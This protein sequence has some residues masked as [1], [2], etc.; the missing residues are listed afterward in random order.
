[1]PSLTLSPILLAS[2]AL[3]ALPVLAVTVHPRG[4]SVDGT[5]EAQSAVDRCPSG[6]S[7]IFA[8]GTYAVSGLHLKGGCTYRGEKGK[9]ILKLTAKDRF[10]FDFSE[11]SDIRIE[12]LVFDGNGLGGGLQA[13]LNGP[14]RNIHV[15]DCA[16]RNVSNKATYPANLAIYSSWAFLDSEIANNTFENIAGG[17]MLT[18]VQHV[19]ISGNTFRDVTLSDAIFIAP[20]PVPFPSGERIVIANNTG[21]GIAKMG[22]EIFRPDPPNG[23]NM[24]EPLIENNSFSRFTAANHE[25]MGLSIT[26]GDGA[27]VRDNR[28]DNTGGVRQDNG[29]GIEVI[30]RNARVTGNSIA[31]GMGFGI[32][33]QGTPGATL[34]SNHISGMWKDGILFACDNGRNRCDSSGSRVEGNT[35]ENARLNGIRLDN[36]WSNSTILSNTI[37]RQAGYWPDDG[38]IAFT[39]IRTCPARQAVT[40][41]GNTVSQT[42]R[43]P[44]SGFAFHGIELHPGLPAATVA[45]NVIRSLSPKPLGEGISGGNSAGWA[46]DRNQ[47]VNL[48]KE[49]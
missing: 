29:I 15:V 28:I 22:L 42:G 26:H 5:R 38:T 30:V 31:N 33:V 37:T 44:P 2:V 16:F 10:I 40:V 13:R 14:V 3:T 4:D 11:R 12:G 27:V 20:N 34:S 46:I 47:F 32:V 43:T 21:S 39:G 35:I 18:T 36:N 23:S 19:N 17:I 8:P 41:R 1:M 48:V 25:A 45:D 7:V 24:T 9:S 49:R 6:G